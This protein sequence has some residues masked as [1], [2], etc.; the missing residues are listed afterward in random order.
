M[1]DI[2]AVEKR[3]A[4]ASPGPKY[5]TFDTHSDGLDE[6]KDMDVWT[7]SG[8]PEDVGWTNDSN[9]RG[10]GLKRADAEFYAHART[11]L[12]AAI[13]EI[14]RLRAQNA[15]LLKALDE[16]QR[17][18]IEAY[19]KLDAD[20]KF[21]QDMAHGYCVRM[22]DAESRL[23]ALQAGVLPEEIDLALK[24]ADA[25][26]KT[27]DKYEDHLVADEIHLMDIARAYRAAQARIAELQTPL[28]DWDSKLAEKN[29]A[30]EK[31]NARIEELQKDIWAYRG[32]LGYAV[33]GSH[34]GRLSGGETPQCGMCG[35]K[36]KRVMF[37]EVQIMSL[38][39]FILNARNLGY[40]AGYCIGCQASEGGAHAEF[41]KL[42][43]IAALYPAA[44]PEA[45]P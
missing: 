32:A 45:K 4:A 21:Q 44:G 39:S 18:R 15:N 20:R 31:R 26:S 13:E 36:E 25:I 6:V 38:A 5:A 8:N 34:D 22:E 24:A 11:D 14:K 30:L 43:S 33:P 10:Y 1:I 29:R 17:D 16:T 19:E 27:R 40:K 7:V 28:K 37:L 9:C 3:I 2:E 41:C 42:E 12:P 23:A 35:S